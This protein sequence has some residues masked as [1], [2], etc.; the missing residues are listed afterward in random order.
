MFGVDIV[1]HWDVGYDMYR[2]RDTFKATFVEADIM[3]NDGRLLALQ[4]QADVI[5]ISAVLHQFDLNTQETICKTLVGF[6]KKGCL[7][8]GYQIGTDDGKED[9]SMGVKVFSQYVHPILPQLILSW[10]PY[11]LTAI[12]QSSPQTFKQMIER[13]ASHTGTV[14][15]VT[16]EML[17]WSTLGWDIADMAW[18]QGKQPISFVAE[19]TS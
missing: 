3:S 13:V 11:R 16:C 14:W 7:L 15:T 6:S 19:R 1:S 18:L 2:D 4:A 17:D 12:S 8:F 5:G 9:E 10:E